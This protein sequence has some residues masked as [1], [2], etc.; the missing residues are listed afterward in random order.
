MIFVAN[1]NLSSVLVDIMMTKKKYKKTTVKMKTEKERNQE[2]DHDSSSRCVAQVDIWH[3][4]GAICEGTYSLALPPPLHA[5]ILFSLTTDPNA[6]T[7]WQYVL[8]LL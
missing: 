2:K 7:F 3:I 8:E 1:I 6:I 4:T 5:H